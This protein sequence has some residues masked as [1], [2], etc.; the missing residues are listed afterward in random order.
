MQEKIDDLVEIVDELTF[1]NNSLA[2]QLAE[3]SENRNKIFLQ[4]QELEKIVF[5]K[6]NEDNS[7]RSNKSKDSLNK[8]MAENEPEWLSDMTRI[9]KTKNFCNSDNI[10]TEIFDKK[11]LLAKDFILSSTDMVYFLQCEAAAL[12]N[13]LEENSQLDL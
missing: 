3:E 6:K 7:A 12:E 1:K 11:T 5:V 9:E 10:S 2:I 4:L 8:S 13:F